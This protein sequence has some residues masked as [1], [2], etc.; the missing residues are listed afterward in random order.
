MKYFL[1]H[2][3]DAVVVCSFIINEQINAQSWNDMK[4]GM[5]LQGMSYDDV[6]ALGEGQFDLADGKADVVLDP[7]QE[8][9]VDLMA[10]ILDG[11]DPDAADKLKEE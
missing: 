6:R 10:D 2:K 9:K 5:T 7:E 11:L 8:E 1:T 4:P 3:P